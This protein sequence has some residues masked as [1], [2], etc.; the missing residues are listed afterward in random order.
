LEPSVEVGLVTVNLDEFGARALT[1]HAAH[2]LARDVK[3]PRQELAGLLGR[4]P[5]ER[6]GVHVHAQRP[7]VAAPH[8][9]DLRAR[10]NVN[11][12][13]DITSMYLLTL[14]LA[15]NESTRDATSADGPTTFSE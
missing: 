12:E 15:T 14:G 11:E 13:S 8:R 7:R 9:I 4:R 2:S 10:M 1:A 5:V 6:S 3:A